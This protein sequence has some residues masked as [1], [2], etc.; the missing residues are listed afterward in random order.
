MTCLP[1][2]LRTLVLATTPITDLISTRMH[3]NHVPESAGKPFLWFRVVSDNEELT[4]D[5]VGGL[6]EA[7][8]DLECTANSES[9]AQNLADAVKTKLHGFQGTMGNETAQAMF[10]RDK[11]DDYIPYS[12]ASDEGAS[13]VSFTLTVWYTT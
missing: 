13:V 12:N 11:D 1:Q 6:H 4:L 8:V 2:D 3:Y 9:A 10:L 7:L 5:G